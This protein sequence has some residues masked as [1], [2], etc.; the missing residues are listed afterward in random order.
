MSTTR[1]L[2][3]AAIR[4]ALI[5]GLGPLSATRLLERVD[6]ASAVFG[7]SMS[8][9]TAIPGIGN[10]RAR[11]ICDPKGEEI[12]EQELALCNQHG[13]R[14]IT[15]EDE[16]YPR[17]LL[18][19]SDPP[20][21]L[22]VT[23]TIE[24]RD[25]L[26][27]AVVGPRRPSVYGHRQAQILSSGLART[28]ACIVS[29]LARGVDTIAHQSAVAVNGRTIAVLGSG[30]GNL[31]PEENSELAE[32]IA[33][34]HG[35]VISEFPFHTKPHAGNFPRRNR[36]VAALALA[37]LV[38]EA[39]KRSGSLITA[40]L[41]GEMGKD[42]L[43]LPGAIDRP[44][45]QGSNQ[46]IRDGATCITGIDDIIEEIEPLRTV[47]Q[48]DHKE[49]EHPRV[50]LLNKRERDIYTLLSDQPRS[51]DDIVR[52]SELPVS[53]ITTTLMSLEL[54]RLAKK[55]AGGYVINS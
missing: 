54:R 46:L 14:I 44:E 1:E 52:V 23:G 53:A 16:D 51:V 41:S 35:A 36:I 38:I 12:L 34:K 33:S 45:S 21:A 13:V 55:A 27:I 19:L 32:T 8:Q 37:C 24:R 9:L 10:E 39:G 50:K 29:G 2:R 48:S 25:Q 43:A 20:L 42:V 18:N 47:H 7:L 5:P 49:Q 26:A 17:A 3:H 31:Y 4:L 28:G 30:F 15:R 40:R 22:W 11:R 6:N